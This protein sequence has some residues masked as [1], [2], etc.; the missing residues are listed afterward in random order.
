MLMKCENMIFM[1][2]LQKKENGTILKIVCQSPQ[3]KR[4]EG[5]PFPSFFPLSRCAPQQHALNR[6]S[7]RRL[8][9]AGFF[10][11]L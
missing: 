2:N 4:E 7:F 6:S 8:L 9:T 3:R 1:L 5:L 11:I 10:A